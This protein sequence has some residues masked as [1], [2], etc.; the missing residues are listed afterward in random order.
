[1]KSRITTYVLIAA[2]VA[3]WGFIA[4]KIFFAKPDDTSAA[5]QRVPEAKPENDEKPQL[6][7]EYK[8]PFL[9]NAAAKPHTPHVSNISKKNTA[10]PSRE[11]NPESPPVKYTG[12]I[13]TGGRVLYVFEHAGLQ[14]MLSPGEKLDGYQLFETWPDSVRFAKNG[15]LFTVHLHN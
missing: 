10:V 4:W 15:E 13:R 12:T 9:K 14:Q 8:D 1:M 5:V 6:L 3:V 2:A 7:L 11:P